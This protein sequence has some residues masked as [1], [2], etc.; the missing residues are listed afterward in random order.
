GR[1]ND[2]SDR[3]KAVLILT[4]RG[5]ET[6]AALMEIRRQTI[7]GLLACLPDNRQLEV[8]NGLSTVRGML[9]GWQSLSEVRGNACCNC[10]DEGSNYK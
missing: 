10:S 9:N 6:A 3:R 7:A 4:D 1:E 2:P 5:Q 8:M